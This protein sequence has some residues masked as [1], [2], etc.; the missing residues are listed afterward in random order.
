MKDEV[1]TWPNQVWC[2]NN[3]SGVSQVTEASALLLLA[4]QSLV[5]IALAT[6]DT[7]AVGS[8]TIT[9][10]EGTVTRHCRPRCSA[11]SSPTGHTQTPRC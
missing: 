4:Y 2:G 9:A 3:I 1:S 5:T 6:T 10:P 7:A 11:T 8:V